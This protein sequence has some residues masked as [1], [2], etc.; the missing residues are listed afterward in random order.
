MS[1][2][3]KRGFTLIE[4]LVVIEAISILIALLLP[5][6][7]KAREAAGDVQ[8]KSNLAGLG[9]GNT[10]HVMDNDSLFPTPF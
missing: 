9:V 2:F 3:C 1:G 10:A 5:V 6:L 4:I 7:S 8:C